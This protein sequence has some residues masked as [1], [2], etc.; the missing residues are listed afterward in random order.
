M[1]L[2]PKSTSILVSIHILSATNSRVLYNALDNEI[3]PFVI[4]TEKYYLGDGGYSNIHGLLTLYRG[5]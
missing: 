2:H 3:D 4:P 5:H 1:T